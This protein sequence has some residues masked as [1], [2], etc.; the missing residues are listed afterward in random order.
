MC[1]DFHLHYYGLLDELKAL[2]VFAHLCLSL[3]PS[4]S[5][6]LNGIDTDHEND[7]MATREL[8]GCLASVGSAGRVPR[9]TFC[10]CCLDA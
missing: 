5:T 6:P 8:G 9:F 2:V 10:L 3:P 4:D 1:P 7:K